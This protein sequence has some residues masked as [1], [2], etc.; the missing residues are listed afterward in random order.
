MG[1]T[2]IFGVA[3]S[4]EKFARNH[5]F[6]DDLKFAQILFLFLIVSCSPPS[7]TEILKNDQLIEFER[8]VG[9]CRHTFCQ[10]EFPDNRACLDAFAMVSAG[11]PKVAGSEDTI[12]YLQN[13][14][15]LS[16]AYSSWLEREADKSLTGR[17]SCSQKVEYI[18]P[19][20][21]DGGVKQ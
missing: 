20:A 4:F 13:R 21:N 5:R 11:Q 1:R 12:R 6:I 7:Q 18:H 16:E 9:V 19:L 17:Y 2:M 15:L 14:L 8:L 10:S 3:H